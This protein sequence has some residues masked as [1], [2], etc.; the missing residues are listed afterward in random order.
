[1]K[2]LGKLSICVIYLDS[3][4]RGFLPKRRIVMSMGQSLPGALARIH[5]AVDWRNCLQKGQKTK[6][7]PVARDFWT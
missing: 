4:F 5:L 7:R 6:E 2:R 3:A 1:M